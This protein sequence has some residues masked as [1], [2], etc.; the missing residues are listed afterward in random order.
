MI[1]GSKK[2]NIVKIMAKG[3]LTT[4]GKMKN[5]N[6]EF[7]SGLNPRRVCLEGVPREYDIWLFYRY[8]NKNLVH[9]MASGTFVF[10]VVTKGASQRL[11]AQY[12]GRCTESISQDS[13]EPPEEP[14]KVISKPCDTC[15][16]KQEASEN[17][18]SPIS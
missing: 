16:V 5:Y 9:D 11:I 14:P 4:T 7:I 13:P 1:K 8:T 6:L 3:R 10:P 2:N 18:N 12:H 15:S 17:V